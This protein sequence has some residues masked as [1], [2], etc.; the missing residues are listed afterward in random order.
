MR[1]G[2]GFIL[3]A[4]AISWFGVKYAQDALKDSPAVAARSPA[5]APQP[6]SSVGGRKVAIL[7][8]PGGHYLSSGVINGRSFQFV[9]D[10]GATSVALTAESANRLGLKLR[11]SDFVFP[12]S[13]ANG[14]IAGAHIV[15]SEV[16]IGTISVDNV[17]A[18][19]LP[20]RALGTNLLGLSFLNRLR[21]FEVGGGQLLLT[22]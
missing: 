21:K 7:A 9:V 3:V 18:I 6:V 17:D 20:D 8:D 19:V 2:I 4:G 14:V 13:T 15:L 10:T 5:P 22:Q 16:R 12:I 11:P 1:F